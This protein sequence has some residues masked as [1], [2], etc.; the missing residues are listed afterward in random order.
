MTFSI[1]YHRIFKVTLAYNTGVNPTGRLWP[2]DL[3]SLDFF[4]WLYVACLSYLTIIY[5]YVYVY[6]MNK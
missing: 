2:Y 3:N 6:S 1:L 5:I 4:F